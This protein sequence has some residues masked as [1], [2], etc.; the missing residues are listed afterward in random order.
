MG[1]ITKWSNK[2]VRWALTGAAHQAARHD[3]RLKGF[4]WG[5]TSEGC[6]CCGQEDACFHLLCVEEYGALSW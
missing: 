6:C 1:G 2:R 4:C 3:P 5:W